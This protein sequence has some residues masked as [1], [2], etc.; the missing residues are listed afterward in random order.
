MSGSAGTDQRSLI[1]SAGAVCA[2]VRSQ[3]FSSSIRLMTARPLARQNS[4][5]RSLDLARDAVE[6]KRTRDACLA[7]LERVAISLTVDAG[8]RLFGPKPSWLSRFNKGREGATTGHCGV[9]D[10]GPRIQPGR[11]QTE[12]ERQ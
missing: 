2:R 11:G 9:H 3:I 1:S 4:P 12:R 7:N 8:P 5:D 6:R 10:Q